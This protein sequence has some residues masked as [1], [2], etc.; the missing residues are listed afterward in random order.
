MWIQITLKNGIQVEAEVEDFTTFKDPVTG[1]L[2][3]LEWVTPANWARK[4]HTVRVNEVVAAVAIKDPPVP[5][6]PTR[7]PHTSIWPSAEELRLYQ[8]R[9]V[10]VLDGRIQVYDDSLKGVVLS[11]NV[12]GLSA[13]AVF[14]VPTE[15]EL[16]EHA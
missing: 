2:V 15:A 13:D 12:S 7:P 6:S 8:G 9:W 1:E 5:P 11:L 14:R 10:A 3:K 4:L 16:N